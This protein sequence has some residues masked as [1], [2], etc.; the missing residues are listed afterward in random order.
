MSIKLNVITT[1]SNKTVEAFNIIEGESYK[2]RDSN[3]VF[4]IPYD[5]PYIIYIEPKIDSI[6]YV[7]FLDLINSISTGFLGYIWIIALGILA[8]ILLRS[9]KNHV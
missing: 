8:F 2:V 3:F 5:S 9:I 6:D 4:T 1:T 7:G